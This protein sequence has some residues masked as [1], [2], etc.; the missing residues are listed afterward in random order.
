MSET[1]SREDV[2]LSGHPSSSPGVL[3]P[4][5]SLH[6]RKQIFTSE[7]EVNAGNIVKV[8]N[9]A[10]EVHQS[11]RQDEIYLEKRLRGI[12]PILDRVKVFNGDI[13]NKICVNIDNQIVTF[14]VAEFVGEPI[15]YVA[16]DGGEE[17]LTKVKQLNSLMF[18]EGKQTKDMTL[19]YKMF[20]AGV[21][22][23]LLLRDKALAVARGEL[24]DEAPFEIYTSDP[25]NTFVIRCNNVQKNIVAGVTYVYLDD[26]DVENHV[27][28]TVYTPD[29]V[30]VLE[31]TP[32]QAERI[33][34]V[35]QH[36]FG[37]VP[38]FEYPCNGVYM[39]PAEVVIP[40]IDAYNTVTSNRVDGVEQ[41]VQALLVFEG[42]EV[43]IE[44][45]RKI[46]ELGALSLPPA[47]DGRQS[48][49]YY[50]CEQLDQKQTQ[51]L[52]DDLYQLILQI[53]GMPSQGN[54][55]TSDSSNNG[56]MIMKSGWWNAEARCL[57]TEG[58]WKD[59]E[60]Q[61]LKAVLKICR[62][63]NVLNDLKLSDI[64]IRFMRH[65][66]EDKTVK[67]QS[68]TSL[69]AAGCSPI[70]AFKLSGIATDPESEAIVFTAYQEQ[71]REEI[72]S[73][74]QEELSRAR[75]EAV[76]A[77]RRSN[78]EAEPADIPETEQIG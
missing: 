72:E 62:E 33:I 9:K 50:L 63:A 7:T 23:R 60:S 78:T 22:Y 51:T 44:E 54:A 18:S 28:Y 30:I 35:T 59:A 57:E 40:L 42:L 74:L 1:V 17:T 67:T 77:G 5:Y 19:A 32:V 8:L 38:L 53:V 65:S 34:S 43:T 2:Q 36:N 69:I 12:Q 11:N 68:F 21:G 3:S 48:K 73:S 4:Y 26:R 39:A 58:M 24:E 61:F 71:K 14:K 41:F 20:T 6:G 75:T 15:Q 66:Y 31:G 16:R 27:Q 70:Q 13:C 29:S 64:D 25:Q 49:V 56:A 45:I 46:K 10:L 52:V 55:N 76:R 37:M 47:M